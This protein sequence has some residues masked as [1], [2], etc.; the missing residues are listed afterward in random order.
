MT[1]L[2]T[3]VW[4]AYLHKGDSQHRK[5]AQLFE[6]FST[7]VMIGIPEYVLLE[8]CTVLMIRDSKQMADSFMEYALD[9]KNIEILYSNPELF[10]ATVQTFRK[11]DSNKLSFVDVALLVLSRDHQV[12]TFDRPLDNLIAK[13]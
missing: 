11:L 13:S 5:A 9:N 7:D 6:D 10:S 4:V 2:D 3:S 1:I 8:V 12:I